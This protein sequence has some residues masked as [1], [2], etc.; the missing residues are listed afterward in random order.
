MKLGSMST[1]GIAVVDTICFDGFSTHYQANK[2][3]PQHS[4]PDPRTY[5]HELFSVGTPTIRQRDIK[6]RSA[7]LIGEIATRYGYKKQ[8]GKGACVN[9]IN[10]EE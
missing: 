6:V 3:K 7:R 8:F 2:S 1:N 9:Y 10:W 4:T 5:L